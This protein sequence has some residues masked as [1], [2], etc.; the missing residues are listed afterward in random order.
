M[1]PLVGARAAAQMAAAPAD[2][3]VVYDVPLLVENRLAAGFDLVVV[4]DADEP[5]RLARLVARGLTEADAT[6]PDGGPG[7]R[8]AAAG[9][10]DLVV[11]N[12]GT[13]EDL[14]GHVDAL[15]GELERRLR[16]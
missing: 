6:G 15:W 13:L 14:D 1:H 12:D 16:T 10:A 3:V 9:A 11:P 7:S 2:A 8:R 5:V 4:V